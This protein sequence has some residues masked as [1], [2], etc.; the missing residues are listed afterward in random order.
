MV[1]QQNYN[2]Q[3]RLNL[4]GAAAATEFYSE[5][6]TKIPEIPI[7]FLFHSPFLLESA[8]KAAEEF[9]ANHHP[10]LLESIRFVAMIDYVRHT[11]SVYKFKLDDCPELDT[12]TQTKWPDGRFF[13]TS[14]F[15][16]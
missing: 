6:W 2:D 7:R 12:E 3:P 5:V 15:E 13:W 16:D 4:D 8:I 14:T 9:L 11:V 1:S 10:S